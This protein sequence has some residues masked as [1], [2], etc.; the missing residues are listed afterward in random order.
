MVLGEGNF[1]LVVSEGNLGWKL[2]SFYDL[3]HVE[4]GKIAEHRG[5]IEAIPQ[6]E[7]WK[8]NNDKF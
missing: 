3:F 5:T 4:N 6:R 8:N 7:S 1:A 2:T